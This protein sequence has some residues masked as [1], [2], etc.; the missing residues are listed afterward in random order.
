MVT[1]KQWKYGGGQRVILPTIKN[2]IISYEKAYRSSFDYSFSHHT[3]SK[4][5]CNYLLTKNN[6]F[7]HELATVAEYLYHRLYLGLFCS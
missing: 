5:L 6:H 3:K 1:F 4:L 2:C 7:P